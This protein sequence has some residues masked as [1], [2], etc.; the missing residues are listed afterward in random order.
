V[1]SL[2]RFS[3]QPTLI[4]PSTGLVEKAEKEKQLAAVRKTSFNLGDR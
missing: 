4:S 2:Y 1:Q 3:H